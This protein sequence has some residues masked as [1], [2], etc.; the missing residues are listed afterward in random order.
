[1]QEN[2]QHSN[3]DTFYTASK[4]FCCKKKKKKKDRIADIDIKF[5]TLSVWATGEET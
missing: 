4:L 1:M 2:T 5:M 3:V